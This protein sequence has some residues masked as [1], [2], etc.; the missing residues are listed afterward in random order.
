MKNIIYLLSSI[1]LFSSCD[2]NEELQDS[3]TKENSNAILGPVQAL[4]TAYTQLQSFQNNDFQFMLQEHPS[5]EMAGP[6]RG[7]DWDD[8]GVWRSLHLHT[9]T[10]ENARIIASFSQLYKGLAFAIDVQSFKGITPSQN[11]QSVFLQSLYIFYIT[12]LFGQVSMRAPGEAVGNLPSIQLKRTEA[13]DFAISKLEAVLNDLPDGSS[14]SAN[15]ANKNAG[16][17][18]LAKM[19]INKA[20]YKATDSNGQPQIGPFVFSTTDMDKVIA[21]S[22]A[23]ML[24]RTL[25]NNY[26]ENF[27]PNNGEISNELIFTS[28]NS[29]TLGGEI[30]RFSVMTLHYNQKPNGWNGFVGLTDLYNK[31]DDQ[32]D[33]RFKSNVTGLTDVSGLNG[34]ILVGQQKNKDGEN[35]LDRQGNPLIFTQNFDLQNSTEEKGMRV[36]KYFADY[37]KP[38]RPSNDF[39]FLRLGDVMLL[40]AEA[41]A[42][43]GNLA[44]AL[45]IINTIRD[46]RGA[47][48]ITSLTMDKI[49]DERGR[50]L[51][52][53]GHRR[54]DQIRFSK[55]HLPVQ[56]RSTTS[57]AN[58][59]IFPIPL[60]A[61]A[62]NP[63]L[64]QNPGY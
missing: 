51:Y 32:S 2:L 31:F 46:K 17:A 5:D 27:G 6:T 61:L 18:L 39:V 35:I 37:S 11:A 56:Q 7:A 53:E 4:E 15:I 42:R 22:N 36:M 28:K 59:L 30:R 40:K 60:N 16:N 25:Q 48:Q 57:S 14:S 1:L 62:A 49:L 21:Y 12:D 29:S 26:F 9:W 13:I 45:T 19:Y 20:V 34:G 63:N 50:E 3:I 55:F 24:G 33:I 10:P 8:N 47:A 64:F 52:W 23:A 43:K 44:D 54:N 41:L 38:E 58:K